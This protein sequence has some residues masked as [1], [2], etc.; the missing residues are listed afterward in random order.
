ME[1]GLILLEVL[2]VAVVVFGALAIFLLRRRPQPDETASL[3]LWPR[4][5]VLLLVCLVIA[6]VE[7]VVPRP[8]SFIWLVLVAGATLFLVAKC[9]SMFLKRG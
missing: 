7:G 6:V 2:T 4:F 1:I 8:F 9:G 3:G 5:S